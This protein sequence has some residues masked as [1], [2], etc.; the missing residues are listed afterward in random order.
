MTE[1]QKAAI[2]YLKK[3]RFGDHVDDW[4][5]L[6]NCPS[7]IVTLIEEHESMICLQHEKIKELE[8]ELDQLKLDHGL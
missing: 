5:F 3:L 2:D 1:T 4:S 7:I 6:Y 8:A